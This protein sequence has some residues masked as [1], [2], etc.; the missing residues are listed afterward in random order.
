MNLLQEYLRLLEM[1]S[2]DNSSSS[3]DE[4]SELLDAADYLISSDD[5]LSD[6]LNEEFRNIVVESVQS[7]TDDSSDGQ[8]LLVEIIPH[9]GHSDG[10]GDSLLSVR[11]SGR[12]V[13]LVVVSG[14]GGGDEAA[15]HHRV[16]PEDL[17]LKI[18]ISRR[19]VLRRVRA[20]RTLR[21]KLTSMLRR[22][23]GLQHHRDA[24][25]VSIKDTVTVRDSNGR[26]FDV[27]M[28]LKL[29]VDEAELSKR[30]SKKKFRHKSGSGCDSGRSSCSSK[31]SKVM[32][33]VGDGSTQ[34]LDWA[35]NSS[36]GVMFTTLPDGGLA[37]AG[38]PRRG[39][40]QSSTDIFRFTT[41]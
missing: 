26:I 34:S 3:S 17:D 39:V 11:L 14:G 12:D 2:S 29:E 5:D 9:D 1:Y 24:D 13:G 30:T 10:D 32:E 40:W 6:I 4:F 22:L 25:S 7:G 37:Y 18:Q 33:E 38:P 36:E 41:V 16:S 20:K 27:E 19:E 35:G 28:D 8:E 15:Y 23:A 31:E 21:K